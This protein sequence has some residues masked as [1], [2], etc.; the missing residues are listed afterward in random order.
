MI[1][2]ACMFY[3]ELDMLELRLRTLED[4]VDYFVVCEADLTHSGLQKPLYLPA[5]LTRFERWSD[6]LVH[7]VISLPT[8]MNSWERERRH[9]SGLRYGIGLVADDNALVV[10]SDCDEIV[11]PDALVQVDPA[12]GARLELEFYYYNARTR[13]KQG[14]SVG[15]LPWSVE[16]EPNRIRTLEGH[17]VPAIDNAGWH[18]SYFLDAEGV[19]DKLDAFMHFA[20]IAEHVPRDPAYVQQRMDAGQDIYTGRGIMFETVPLA[21]TLP[22]ALLH[23]DAYESWR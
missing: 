3:K 21:D 15:C 20:D 11:R 9:R 17:T 10:V 7:T 19:V 23:D 6:R 2:D 1:I 8:D 13:V 5:N 18:F 12:V 4:V 22:F 14:W 16:Q